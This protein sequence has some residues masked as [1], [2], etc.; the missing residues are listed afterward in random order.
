MIIE[1]LKGLIPENKLAKIKISVPN[2]EEIAKKTMNHKLGIVGGISILGTTGIARAMSSK[3]YKDSIVYQLNVAIASNI[4]DL[5]FVPGNIGEK[6]ALK[7]LNV[8]KDQIVQTGNY[9]GFMLEE[10]KLRNITKLTFFGHIGK[11]VKIAGGIFN[12]KH[13]IADGR[14][15]IIM[16]HAALNGANKSTIKKLFS[17]KTTED[18]MNILKDE[19]IDKKVSNSIASSIK[20][21]CM[22]RFN[23][24]MDVFLVDMDGNFLNTNFRR[25]I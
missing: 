12:T 21:R 11:L 25:L 5:V 17:S 24:E 14:K 16:A 20:D 6:L 8:K 3:A 4:T 19:N 15:E 23:I 10:A 13:S 22:E 2:G 7:K 18:M 1:N 9:V